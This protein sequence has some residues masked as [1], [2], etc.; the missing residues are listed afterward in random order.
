M[1]A[2]QDE[3]CK[4][5]F[6]LSVLLHANEQ[7]GQCK[8]VEIIQKEQPNKSQRTATIDH[9]NTMSCDL[10]LKHIEIQ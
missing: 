10:I 4:S 6:L 9:K 8:C 5:F 7:N 1:F 3:K 2:K